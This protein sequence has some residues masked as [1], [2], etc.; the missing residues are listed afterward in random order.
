M[1]WRRVG[2]VQDAQIQVVLE[3]VD[4]PPADVTLILG[5]D[6]ADLGILDP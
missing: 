3:R 2:T 5:R 4:A 6:Y 1:A